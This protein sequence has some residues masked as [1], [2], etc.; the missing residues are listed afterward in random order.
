M[1]KMKNN[2][3]TLKEKAKTI[4]ALLDQNK[5]KIKLSLPET[6]STDKM[7]AVVMNAMRRTP[8]IA[9]CTPVSVFNA[10]ITAAQLGILPDDVLGYAYIIPFKNQATLIPGYKGLIHLALQS[11]KIKK[12][13]ARI[14]YEN[15]D[16][17]ITEGTRPELAH[18]PLAPEVRGNVMGAYCVVDFVSGDIDF[19][20]MWESEI[21]KIK[22]SSKA[23]NNGPWQTHPDEMRKKT[24]IKRAMKT[25]DL[26]P[27]MTQAITLD[28]PMEKN[29]TPQTPMVGEAY[30][31]DDWEP[32]PAA[33]AEVHGKPDVAQPEEA[34][35]KMT[36][37]E[38]KKYQE[39]L[40]LTI[41]MEW[42]E[43]KT[44][45]IENIIKNAGMDAALIAVRGEYAKWKKK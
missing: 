4:H 29:I 38:E 25:L 42:P 31:I 3:V 16:F 15:E 17:E 9:E 22:N 27:Q 24:V 1:I 10:V 19:T 33:L 2:I 21:Q 6:L 40:D 5:E 11:G 37:E 12:I 23:A 32:D 8:K 44:V 20:F 35:E 26:S 7:I 45:E 28:D 14:V 34:G 30:N 39:I 43:N 13:R 18:V 36:A 41:A